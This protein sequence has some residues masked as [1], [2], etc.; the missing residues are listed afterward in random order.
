MQRALLPWCGRLLPATLCHAVAR[1]AE[2]VIDLR[3]GL[4]H[5]LLVHCAVH[6]DDVAK[7]P[8]VDPQLSGNV[9]EALLRERFA[10]FGRHRKIGVW[11]SR[12]QRRDEY[13]GDSITASCA[14]RRSRFLVKTVGTQTV[15]SMDR[16]MNQRNSRLY[17]VCSI[18]MRSERML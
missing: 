16:P 4:T 8:D 12:E 17:W 5:G 18:S 2:R 10:V 3:L 11:R 15:S 6:L 7:R 1:L 13:L 14:I 9:L